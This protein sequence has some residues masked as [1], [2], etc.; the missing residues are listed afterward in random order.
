MPPLRRAVLIAL[1]FALV[2]ALA[3]ACRPRAHETVTALAAD[4]AVSDDSALVTVEGETFRVRSWSFPL[5][6]TKLA[7]VD[8]GIS[9]DRSEER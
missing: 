3:T 9:I 8:L 5:A 4:A 1:A 6:T 7:L 2:A